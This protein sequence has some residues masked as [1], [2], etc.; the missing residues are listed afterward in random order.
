MRLWTVNYFGALGGAGGTNLLVTPAQHRV[1]NVAL[2]TSTLRSYTNLDLRLF[3][4]GNL[5]RSAALSDAPV[6]RRRRR[7]RHASG[8]V[9]VHRAGRRRSRR[10]D[11][12]GLDH[13][14]AGGGGTWTSLDLSQCV[15]PLP[16]ACGAIEDSRLWKGAARGRACRPPVRRP[17]RERARPRLARRQPRRV[18][19]ARRRA[20]HAATTLALVSPPISGTFGDSPAVTAALTG[21]RRRPLG[22]K[23]RDDRDRRLGRG[24]AS[25]APTAA[26]RSRCRSRRR[27][28]ATSS[29]R[30]FGGDAT[31]VPS[32][33][34]GAVLDRQGAVEPVL[35]HAAAAS[36]PAA[37]PPG[38]SRP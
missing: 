30:S 11:P 22:G 1:A 26:S 36:S 14:R 8:G 29:S 15:A 18:L 16:A 2:G 10:G 33:D 32:S 23:T 28:A 34:V 37:A 5:Q 31:H 25:P 3:Y 9:D 19:P 27:R 6:D 13:V 12:S 24:S 38:S 7:A 35:L 4:S 20:P 21:R 17:G